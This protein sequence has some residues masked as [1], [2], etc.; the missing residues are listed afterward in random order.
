MLPALFLPRNVEVFSF[1]LDDS[2]RV[3]FYNISYKSPNDT[4]IINLSGQSQF[5]LDLW[6]AFRKYLGPNLVTSVHNI[7]N[8][9]LININRYKDSN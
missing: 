7:I 8:M 6:N 1:T 5:P 3:L 9:S 4:L 2:G